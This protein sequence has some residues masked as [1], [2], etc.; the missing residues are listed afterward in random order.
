MKYLYTLLTMVF[1]IGVVS[2]QKI[3]YK[4]NIISVDGKE[5][6]KVNKIKDH[7]T[8]GLTSTF[9]LYS[10]SGK[11]LVIAAYA[12]EYD[13]DHSTNMTF[14]YRFTFLTT[15]QVGIFSISKL[16]GEKSFAKLIGAAGV[17]VNDDLDA[18]KVKEF[19]AM[20]GKD[21]AITVASDDYVLERRDKAW[22]V[23]LKTDKT[24]EQAQSTI[25]G[26]KDVSNPADGYDTYQ[27]S[28]PSG[29][30]AAKLSFTGGN[31]AQAF[32]V[33]TMKDQIRR[34]VKIP[35]NERV[36][37]ASAD[38]DRNQIALLRIIKWLVT[39]NYL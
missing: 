35:T 5:I 4:N 21:P 17:I 39:N 18:A 32:D 19:I 10:M 6:A 24:I 11:K 29:I 1:T 16:G 3:D 22:P 37:L 20:K 15:N 27:I 13:R 14:Y 23:K 26:F 36:M 38:E 2:A 7:E 9:E 25:G 33:V 12:S 30:V 34:Q 8:F 28:L 31:N